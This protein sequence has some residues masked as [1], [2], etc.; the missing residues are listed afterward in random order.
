MPPAPP[1]AQL[2]LDLAIDD[3]LDLALIGS[4]TEPPRLRAAAER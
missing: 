1:G 4:S 3:L 2:D